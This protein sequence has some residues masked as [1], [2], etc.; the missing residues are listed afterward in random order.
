MTCVKQEKKYNVVT[1]FIHN[2]FY[3]DKPI[4]ND[5]V[6]VESNIETIFN[7]RMNT[8]RS[9]Y[10]ENYDNKKT[11][12]YIMHEIF[13]GMRNNT[14]DSV[15]QRID[16]NEW[17]NDTT[18]RNNYRVFATHLKEN[19]QAFKNA[20]NLSVYYNIS[21]SIN[22][23]DVTF[24]VSSDTAF[25]GY[26]ASQDYKTAVRKMMEWYVSHVATYQHNHDNIYR[27]HT[28][29]GSEEAE[30]YYNRYNLQNYVGAGGDTSF[31]YARD[32]EWLK[33][34]NSNIILYKDFGG[35]GLYYCQSY[36]ERMNQTHT[37]VGDDCTGLVM[38][39]IGYYAGDNLKDNEYYYGTD[40][41]GNRCYFQINDIGTPTF[42]WHYRKLSNWLATQGHMYLYEVNSNTTVN[43][44]EFGD[45]LITCDSSVSGHAEFYI[46]SE[47]TWGW[48]MKHRTL[49][50]EGKLGWKGIVEKNTK[51]ISGRNVP[52]FY[53]KDKHNYYKDTND[54]E[55]SITIQDDRP[56]QY[57]LSPNPNKRNMTA[58]F[59]TEG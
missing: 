28:L 34:T 58:I 5:R 17:T 55:G 52:C 1:N 50:D 18:R 41:K 47:H 24:R 43:D 48:G 38:A 40:N 33:A 44:L 14:L 13:E 57:V 22:P 42:R 26:E 35:R 8:F 11:D 46:D 20:R 27:G 2:T 32:V 45:I 23:N 16:R 59:N 30:E 51:V 19:N 31:L 56:Y 21:K 15:I 54:N 12:E 9:S 3:N 36:A 7:G 25:R 4:K 37:L 53:I 39:V 29:L 10:N 49:Y 6:L